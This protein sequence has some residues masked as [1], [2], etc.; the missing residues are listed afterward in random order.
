MV[1]KE[2]WEYDL[3]SVIDIHIY[4]DGHWLYNLFCDDSLHYATTVFYTLVLDLTFQLERE[5]FHRCFLPPTRPQLA[6][7]QLS[8]QMPEVL[9]CM[10]NQPKW[11][12]HLSHLSPFPLSP[13]GAPVTVTVATVTCWLV[14]FLATWV[15]TICT[16]SWEAVCQVNTCHQRLGETSTAFEECASCYDIKQV[17]YW[18][19]GW[20]ADEIIDW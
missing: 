16:C 7:L 14:G 19:H 11:H 6:P 18:S 4:T 10:E 20:T 13:R 2:V 5:S 15:K 12:G 8:R 1:L 17:S 9:L 3:T